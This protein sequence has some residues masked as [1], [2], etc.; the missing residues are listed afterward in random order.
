MIED[1]SSKPLVVCARG[2]TPDKRQT[3]TRSHTWRPFRGA[4]VYIFDAEGRAGAGGCTLH[5]SV[6]DGDLMK[7]YATFLQ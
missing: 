4:Y 5:H 3:T 2:C 7:D 1:V 6:M